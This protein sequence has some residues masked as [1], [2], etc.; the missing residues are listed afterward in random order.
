MAGRAEKGEVGF[1]FAGEFQRAQSAADGAPG[2]SV[3]FRV[4][5]RV[6]VQ[7]PIGVGDAL[8]VRLL[9]RA[10]DGFIGHRERFFPDDFDFALLA[11][12]RQRASHA[13]RPLGM[14]WLRVA[15]AAFIGDHVHG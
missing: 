14:A 13:L 4:V 15:E 2:V 9:V 1:A 3:D 7:G 10:G 6:A 5:G 12:E 8:Q 11:Q